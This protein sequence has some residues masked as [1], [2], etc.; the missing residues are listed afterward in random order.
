[1][2]QQ[3]VDES[4]CLRGNTNQKVSRGGGWTALPGQSRRHLGP[5]SPHGRT[6]EVPGV[7]EWVVLPLVGEGR[8]AQPSPLWWLPS[9]PPFPLFLQTVFKPPGI[10]TQSNN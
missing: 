10:S 4:V 5:R 3:A 2:L 9:C 7:W 8:L 1:V 6:R